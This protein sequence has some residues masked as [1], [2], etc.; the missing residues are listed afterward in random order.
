MYHE[1]CFVTTNPTTKEEFV[2]AIA[3]LK[4]ACVNINVTEMMRTVFGIDKVIV[5]AQ[6]TIVHYKQE[7]YR[8]IIKRL[9]ML[10][11]NYNKNILFGVFFAE[12]KRNSFIC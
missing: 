11:T 6:V 10:Y 1:H 9:I 12:G 8:Y 3:L 7:C 4:I 5:D 2:C